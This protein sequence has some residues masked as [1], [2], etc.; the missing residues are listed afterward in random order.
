MCHTHENEAVALQFIK[1]HEY[2]I[3]FHPL[4]P[5]EDTQYNF[6]FE[7]DLS[8]I[9]IRLAQKKYYF[10]IIIIMITTK[11]TSK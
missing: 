8:L 2:F 4:E 9:L 11:N 6:C 5:A 3:F 10:R 7:K 1:K